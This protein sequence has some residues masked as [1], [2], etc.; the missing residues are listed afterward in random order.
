[1]TFPRTARIRRRQVT[2]NNLDYTVEKV[3]E[4]SKEKKVYDQPQDSYQRHSFTPRYS[5]QVEPRAM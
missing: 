2:L 5:K 3:I 1:M 4:K